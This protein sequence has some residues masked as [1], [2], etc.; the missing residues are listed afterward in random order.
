MSRRQLIALWGLAALLLVVLWARDQVRPW[1]TWQLAVTQARLDFVELQAGEVEAR[2][3]PALA[4][5]ESALDAA[6][7]DAR[8]R[9]ADRKDLERELFGLERNARRARGRLDGSTGDERRE[10]RI[11]VET[12]EEM[13]ADRRRRLD[14]MA[15]PHKEAADALAATRAPLD[16]LYDE[17]RELGADRWLR[18]L[19]GLRHLSPSLGVKSA[20][21][22]RCVTCHLGGVDGLDVGSAEGLP[23]VS[24][25]VLA[26]HPRRALLDLHGAA[27]VGCVSC[28]G[29]DPAAT[30]LAAAG[31]IPQD[32][33][34]ADRWRREW[35][36]REGRVREPILTGTR[37][38]AGCASCHG[39]DAEIPGAPAWRRGLRLAANLRCGACHGPDP[40][41]D[42]GGWT[43]PSVDLTD[44]AAKTTRTR[45]AR[46]LLETEGQRKPD[47]WR[48]RPPAERDVEVAALVEALW[49]RA[50]PAATPS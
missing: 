16:A 21:G 34:T 12:L 17:V 27:A 48:G 37:T 4:E 43:A 35:G 1:K 6:K 23:D 10:A 14:A 47:F 11:E 38:V 3:A 46:R 30:D 50:R 28:H 20:A 13:A 9:R 40:G 45:A 7:D 18:R 5:L 19:P 41:L 15:A 31:H 33:E 22:E 42:F 32:P 8:S 36:W 26:A 24:P 2:L 49:H 44:V 39:G 25:A 29:G